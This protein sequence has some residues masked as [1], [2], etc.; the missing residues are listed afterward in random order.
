MYP[1]PPA[2]NRSLYRPMMGRKI[3]GVC[4]GIGLYF[5]ID[6]S[7]V[8]IAWIVFTLV[9]GSGFLAYL[10]AWLVMPAQNG[11]RAATPLVLLILLFGIP[12]MCYLLTLPFQLLFN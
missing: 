5:G 12:F 6:P 9:G 10:I 4:E 11:Q 8:R 3:A 7:I 1:V 2:N